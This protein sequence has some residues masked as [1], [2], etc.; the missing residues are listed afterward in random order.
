M[1]RPGKVVGQPEPLVRLRFG[2]SGFPAG[3][4]ADSARVSLQASVLAEADM[5]R[6]TPVI[7]G[8]A[9]LGVLSGLLTV[10]F[11]G[12]LFE[13]A[14]MAA[15]GLAG[16]TAAVVGFITGRQVAITT[17]RHSRYVGAAA[18]WGS[19]WILLLG[20]AILVAAAVWFNDT[21]DPALDL[22]GRRPGLVLVP[23]GVA[24]LCDGVARWLGW[25]G[26]YKPDASY[27]RSR[28]GGAASVVFGGLLLV[29][30]VLELLAPALFDRTFDATWRAALAK[31][32]GRDSVP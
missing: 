25:L 9:A 7:L 24:V 5:E 28:V 22:I 20:V 23:V 13:A 32:M 21:V 8:L 17:M 14:G 31:L 11:P 26:H 18:R 12:R 1:A 6:G 16:V 30:G 3:P 29:I 4:V 2:S 10:V 19:V 15:F 27:H